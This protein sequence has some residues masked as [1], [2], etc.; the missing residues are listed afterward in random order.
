MPIARM[1]AQIA[2]T[3]QPRATSEAATALPRPG[4]ATSLPT[5]MPASADAE[6]TTMAVA[7]PAH[8]IAMR[9]TSRCAGKDSASIRPSSRGV[10]VVTIQTMAPAHTAPESG[11]PVPE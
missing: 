3:H 6:T 2:A 1:T 4:P 8:T 5:G 11:D 9:S 10:A 7:H